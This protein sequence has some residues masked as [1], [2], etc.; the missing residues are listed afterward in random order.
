MEPITAV[1]I[2]RTAFAKVAR[3]CESLCFSAAKISILIEWSL[4]KIL[5]HWALSKKLESNSNRCRRED[6]N[7][8]LLPANDSD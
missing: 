2:V 7:T 1:Q 6:G 5:S 8:L 3:L 4:P